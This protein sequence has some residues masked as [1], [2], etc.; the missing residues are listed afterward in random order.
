[1]TS[2]PPRIKELSGLT[3]GALLFTL[4]ANVAV[5]VRAQGVMPT[6]ATGQLS[7]MPVPASVQT[8]PERLAIND[9]FRVATNVYHNRQYCLPYLH[10]APAIAA[11]ITDSGV[12]SAMGFASDRRP[13]LITANRSHMP[14]NSGK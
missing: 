2:F 5:A 12:Q 14:N 9:A 11:C 3:S 10:S 13:R 8:Q 6:T 7:L 4:A 1:M